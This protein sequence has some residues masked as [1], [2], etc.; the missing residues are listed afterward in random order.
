MRDA[1]IGRE[2][3]MRKTVTETLLADGETPS[4][5]GCVG[6]GVGVGI[7]LVA[8]AVPIV[9]ADTTKNAS[10]PAPASTNGSRTYVVFRGESIMVAL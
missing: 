2:R 4:I 9:K 7:A 6:V 1:R 10:A 8:L 3:S 5:L